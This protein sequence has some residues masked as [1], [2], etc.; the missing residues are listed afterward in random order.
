MIQAVIKNESRQHQKWV[1]EFFE[2]LPERF[3]PAIT[4]RYAEKYRGSFRE[5]NLM[6]LDTADVLGGGRM[7]L[8]ADEGELRAFAKARADECLRALS[9]YVDMELALEAMEAVPMRYGI[10][11][12]GDS[13]TPS[14][15]RARLMCTKWW[16]RAVRC[17]VGRQVEGA[18]VALGLVHRR[19]GLYASN[20]T[21]ARRLSQRRKNRAMLESIIAVNEAQPEGKR[22]EYTLAELSDLGVSNPAIRRME[23]MTRIAGFDEI[24]KA[25]GHAAEFY[26]LTAPSKYHARESKSGA[27]NPKYNGSTPRETQ[28][29]LCSVW[30]KIRAT[31][32]RR[33]IRIYG[34]RVAEPHHDGTPHW[35]MVLFMEPGHVDEVR[36]V[37]SRYALKVDGS[38]RGAAEHRFTAKTIDRSKGNAAGYLAKYIAKNIDGYGVGDDYE[39]A[40]GDSVDS[41]KR[42][43]AW[44]ACWGIRQ[45]QQ[46]GGAPVTVWRELRRMDAAEQ[47]SHFMQA[48]VTAADA[49]NWAAYVELQGG[50]FAK[51]KDYSV[52]SYRVNGVD[53]ETGEITFNAYGEI[54]APAM[55]GVLFQAVPIVT[56]LGVWVFKRSGAAVPP[57]SSVNNCNGGKNGF[58]NEGGKIGRF[59]ESVDAGGGW[60]DVAGGSESGDSGFG[61]SGRGHGAGN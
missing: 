41:A 42:V 33:G 44:A 5:A 27:E 9:R 49:G 14:G 47:E 37:M 32:H 40:N 34:F 17:F 3:K 4:R 20:E 60:F 10:Q 50:A 52:S 35:H 11:P 54:A 45:F 57:W 53:V 36:K 21:V 7:N 29:Y 30:A 19:E 46:I 43:D 51:R 15:R 24:A 39:A 58:S 31:L 6:L 22:N 38:E 26:T 61:A 25:Y 16:R 56:R 8:A 12:P 1:A 23:L 2:K 18:A 13:V 28:T 59:G 55:K 48:I